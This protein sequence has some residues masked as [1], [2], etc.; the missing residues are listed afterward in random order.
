MEITGLL[1]YMLAALSA[2]CSLW[3]LKNAWSSI[4]E[5]KRISIILKD[6]PKNRWLLKMGMREQ[7]T[8][9]NAFGLR[10]GVWRLIK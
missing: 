7:A 1:L 5:T 4:R 9:F 10:A 8:C 6:F 2:V 3:A